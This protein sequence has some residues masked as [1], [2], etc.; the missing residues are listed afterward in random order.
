VKR[1]L[2]LG[3]AIVGLGVFAFA[4]RHLDIHALVASLRSMKP[5]SAVVAMMVVL[6][7]KVGTKAVRSHLLITAE[8]RRAGCA[9]PSMFVTARL[10]FASH[11]AGQLA[12]GPLGFTVRTVAL[13]AEGIPIKS[14][15]RVH[16]A[17][18]IAEACGLVAVALVAV[19]PLGSLELVASVLGL[20]LL[21]D[22]ALIS[23]GPALARA[24]VWAFASSVA[25]IAVLMLASRAMHVELGFVPVVLAFLAINAAYLLPTPGQLGVQEAA[26]TLAFAAAGIA[27][28]E[29]LACALAYRCIHLVALGAVGVPALVVTWLPK[30]R[31]VAV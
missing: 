25:D 19:M 27:A 1:A 11:A 13:Q 16:V 26:I 31:E 3:A 28:P 29:A 15:A 12:W 2:Q 20:V 7:G 18:R 23:F 22:L 17:E 10:L 9:T 6:V 30:R 8:C 14:V 24:T 5:V 4:A 21:A